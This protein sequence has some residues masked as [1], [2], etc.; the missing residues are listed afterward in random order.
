MKKR[1]LIGSKY[2]ICRG[3]TDRRKCW[4]G[5]R[6]SGQGTYTEGYGC[7]PIYGSQ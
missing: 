6:T 5:I 2:G 7:E 3:N 4:S 1:A